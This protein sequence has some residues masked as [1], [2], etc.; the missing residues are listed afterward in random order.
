MW[1]IEIEKM[2]EFSSLCRKTPLSQGRIKTELIEAQWDNILRFVATIK[3]KENSAS[4]L[5]KRFSSY[6]REHPLYRALKQFGR[7]VILARAA[8]ISVS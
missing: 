4:Q 7:V 2:W 6:S 8:L 1:F 5:L 3:L